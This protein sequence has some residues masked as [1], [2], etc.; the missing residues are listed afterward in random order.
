MKLWKCSICGKVAF[1]GDGWSHYS[2]PLMED[3]CPQWI[4]VMCGP[5]CVAEFKTG[6]SNGTIVVPVL[7]AR[8][9]T[10]KM[11]VQPKGYAPQPKQRDLLEQWN[12]E[13]PSE[14]IRTEFSP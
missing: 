7:K 2:S 4:P 1:W 13:H 9:Y 12:M 3:E 11:T 10:V 14:A 8:G 5:R 6:V